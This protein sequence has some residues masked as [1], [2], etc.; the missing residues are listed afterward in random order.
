[1]AFRDKQTKSERLGSIVSGD[2]RDRNR[3][4]PSMV[5]SNSAAL[6]PS[7]GMPVSGLSASAKKDQSRIGS[8]AIKDKGR[9]TKTMNP[10]RPSSNQTPMSVSGGLGIKPYNNTKP[11]YRAGPGKTTALRD[12]QYGEV[13]VTPATA[14][15]K[16]PARK[17]TE[18]TTPGGGLG[19]AKKSKPKVNVTRNT[20][21][22]L[23]FTTGKVT[24]STATKS[25][26]TGKSSMSASQ[27]ATQ[28]A[29]N[30]GGVAG[31][32]KNAAGKNAS[33]MTG[34]RK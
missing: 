4:G 11:S 17:P 28:N 5:R 12:Y 23:G 27:R 29:Y 2:V 20:G 14:K 16:A 21:S 8:T 32:T 30:K 15:P 33:S 24:G 31:P 9:V 7:L 34:K 22:S 6:S 13:M 25:V 26:S 19:M 1:M 3:A 10:Y 18:I